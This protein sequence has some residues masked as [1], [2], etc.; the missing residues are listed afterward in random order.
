[1]GNAEEVGY[2]LV[3][4]SILVPGKVVLESHEMRGLFE[5]EAE[6]FGDEEEVVIV[7]LLVFA[8]FLHCL[9]KQPFDPLVL[10]VLNPQTV[11]LL[12][13]IHTSR[14]AIIIIINTSHRTLL[15]QLR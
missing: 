14:L 13:V 1:M 15:S 8:L 9:E 5:A 6:F 10:H 4:D 7:D 12:S 11:T 3:G 2:L